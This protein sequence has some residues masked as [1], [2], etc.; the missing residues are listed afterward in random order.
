MMASVM[1]KWKNHDIKAFSDEGKVS[2]VDK[3]KST[4]SFRKM[5]IPSTESCKTRNK[6]TS[7]KQKQRR[8]TRCSEWLKT[9]KERSRRR[10]N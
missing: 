8:D 5:Y 4:V 1:K 6:P 10:S 2:N 9:K 3:N 7:K